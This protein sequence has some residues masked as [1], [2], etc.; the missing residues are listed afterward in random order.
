MDESRVLSLFRPFEKGTGGRFGLG[1]SIVAKVVKA[2]NYK[3]RGY[4]TEDGVCFQIWRDV[5]IQL[6]KDRRLR[7]DLRFMQPNRKDKRNDDS[8]NEQKD[9]TV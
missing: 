2:N 4:N 5:P 3:V 1:L 8:V 6:V 9:D 7:M